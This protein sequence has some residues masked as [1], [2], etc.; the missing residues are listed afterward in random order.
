VPTGYGIAE[1]VQGN[2]QTIGTVRAD[3][4]QFTVRHLRPHHHYRFFV[5]SFT[6]TNESGSITGA[7]R[8]T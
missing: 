8:T 7:W 6:S 3:R 5:W 2:E 1:L 4:H